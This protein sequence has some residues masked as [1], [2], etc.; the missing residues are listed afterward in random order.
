MPSTSSEKTKHIGKNDPCWCGSGKKYKNCHLKV[1]EKTYRKGMLIGGAI[2][3]PLLLISI[4]LLISR[5]ADLS[6]TLDYFA[7]ALSIASGLPYIIKI[8]KSK[9]ERLTAIAFFLIVGSILL[10]FYGLFFVCSVFH[11][12]L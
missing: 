7:L 11:D 8:T 5:K 2:V 3:S 6:R 12:C 9:V 1:D 4:Y 10:S